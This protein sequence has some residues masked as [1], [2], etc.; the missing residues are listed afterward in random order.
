MKKTFRRPK[1]LSNR[2]IDEIRGKAS[3]GCAS[4]FEL[5]AVFAHIDLMESVLDGCDMDSLFGIE[6]WRRYFGIPED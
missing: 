4:A 2:T 6:G 3:V 1:F 5:Q